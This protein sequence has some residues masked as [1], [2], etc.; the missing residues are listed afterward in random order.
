MNRQQI[1]R[2]EVDREYGAV[3]RRLIKFEVIVETAEPGTSRAHM[4]MAHGFDDIGTFV[5]RK[6]HKKPGHRWKQYRLFPFDR[7]VIVICRGELP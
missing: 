2:M 7:R 6:A 3:P 1:E 4:E 5:Y